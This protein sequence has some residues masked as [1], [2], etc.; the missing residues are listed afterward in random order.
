[1]PILLK[2]GRCGKRYKVRDEAAGRRF[3]C[4]GCGS[5]I[6]VPVKHQVDS[7]DDFLDAL[8]ALTNAEAQAPAYGG[9]ERASLLEPVGG[10][11]KSEKREKGSSKRKAMQTVAEGLQLILIAIGLKVLVFLLSLILAPLWGFLGSV[12]EVIPK[13]LTVASLAAAAVTIGGQILCM[14]VPKVSRAREIIYVVLAIEVGVFCI[15]LVRVVTMLVPVGRFLPLNLLPA[16]AIA[17]LSPLAPLASAIL[18]LIFL[19]RLSRYVNFP[20]G[21]DLAMEIF[22]LGGM[23]MASLFLAVLFACLPLIGFVLMIIGICTF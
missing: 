21:E 17:S 22:K 7:D 23:L 8:G 9:L 4:K 15:S 19:K 5:L 18:F 12:S 16:I 13:S 10:K 11:P 20:A 2:C 14:A 3:K 1:M 6:R